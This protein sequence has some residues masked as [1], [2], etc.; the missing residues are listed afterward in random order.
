MTGKQ[1]IDGVEPVVEVAIAGGLDEEPAVHGHN[2]KIVS[3]LI[4]LKFHAV[5]VTKTVYLC[6]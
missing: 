2:T 4:A 5:F 1:G 6:L 3:S